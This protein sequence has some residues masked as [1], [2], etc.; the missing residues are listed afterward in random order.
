MAISTTR[1]VCLYKH[2]VGRD[3]TTLTMPTTF[4]MSVGMGQGEQLGREGW[5]PPSAP[6]V[7]PPCVQLW[8]TRF[9]L[10]T[11]MQSHKRERETS[12]HHSGT[13]TTSS[14]PPECFVGHM[15]WDAAA[16]AMKWQA[17]YIPNRLQCYSKTSGGFRKNTSSQKLNLHLPL[18]SIC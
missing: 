7:L 18:S 17:A 9:N 16:T 8:A 12:C 13:A 11:V 5:A 4:K 3:Q 6:K 2:T 10:A 15:V 14:W 1:S